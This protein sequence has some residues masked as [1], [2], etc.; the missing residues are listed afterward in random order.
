[1]SFLVVMDSCG[2]LTEDMKESGHFAS[3]PFLID[4]AGSHFVDNERFD[5]K[6][7][8]RLVKESPTVARTACPSPE[9]FRKLFSPEAERIYVVTISAAPNCPDPIT[10]RSLLR[11]WRMRIIRTE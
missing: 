8:L 10:V 5:M 4:I 6:R 7:F 2:E 11:I 9:R 1:M 3:V